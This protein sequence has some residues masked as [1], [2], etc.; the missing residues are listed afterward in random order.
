MTELTIGQRIAQER[1]KQ[2]LSQM[3]LA[4]RL[5]VSRQAI[6][7]WES[8]AAIPE[9]DKLIA[10]SRLF[11][12]S[13]GWLLGVE[14]QPVSGEESLS[15]AQFQIVEKLVKKYQ[16]PQR[17]HLTVFHYLFAIGASLLVFLFIYGTTARLEQHL[18]MYQENLVSLEQRLE[19]LEAASQTVT[20]TSSA[21]GQLLAGYSFDLYPLTKTK[22]NHKVRVTFSGVPNV[23]NPEDTGYLCVNGGNS[24]PEPVRVKCVWDGSRLTAQADLDVT[25]GY[26]LCFAVEHPGGS[27]EQQIL[28]DRRLQYLGVE[29]AIPIRI[30][31]GSYTCQDG[32]LTLKDFEINFNLPRIY[33]NQTTSEPSPI[34]CEYRLYRRPQNDSRLELIRAD[35]IGRLEPSTVTDYRH[36]VSSAPVTFENVVTENTSYYQLSFYMELDS[37]VSNEVPITILVPDGKGGLSQ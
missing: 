27:R 10:L 6:S 35:V 24:C 21:P 34:R 28:E 33:E 17:P 36:Q 7:K 12:V 5:E 13:V 18:L 31:H 14:E 16:E 2:N 29:C 22:S 23:W 25:D 8:D 20:Q 30:T 3:G 15:E 37:G 19:T 26:E 9:I 1:K 32:T 11:H 4:A